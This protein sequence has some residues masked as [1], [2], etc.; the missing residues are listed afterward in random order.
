M[1]KTPLAFLLIAA[2]AAPALSQDPQ[3]PEK[4]AQRPARERQRQS[5]SD[6]AA[7]EAGKL[8]LPDGEAEV[9]YEQV[10]ARPDDIQ[11]NYRY[12]RAQVRRGEVK[13]AAA[14]LERILLVNPNLVRVRLFYALVLYRLDNLAE[15]KT[16]LELVLKSNPPDAL[17]AEAER[18]KKDVEKKSKKTQLSGRVSVGFQY[19]TNRNAAPEAGQ[20]LFLDNP[21]NLTGTGQ[22]RDDTSLLFMVNAEGRRDLG[23]QAGHDA[24]VTLSYYRA[25]QTL[26]K[27][28][29]LAAYSVQAGATY[30]RGKS[31]LVPSFL[32]DHVTLA[33]STY[34]RNRG[35]GLRAERKLDRATT[36]SL[37]LRAVYQ[38]YVRTL[39]VP[40]ADER[41]GSQWD[42]TL[43]V[44]RILAPKHRVTAGLGY[45]L[46][47]ASREYNAYQRT[48]ISGG[49]TWLLGK[50]AFLLTNASVNWDRYEQPDTAISRRFRRD[51]TFRVSGT[52]GAPL[53]L[54]HPK[55]KDFVGTLTYEHYHALSSL[56]NYEYM[57]NKISAL[58]TYKWELGL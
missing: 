48:T 33:Q 17:R 31:S 21:V 39:Q 2:L 5:E 24:F 49:H 29:N 41:D 15:A 19:D 22:R 57:N 28:L 47:N 45:S 16:Q 11:L 25:E 58:L 14:T 54:A 35:A 53:T 36:L 52:L 26:V 34:L 30:K 51:T 56:V 50:G 23:Y 37:D 9:T 3:D 4:E 13:G 38:D 55:L 27:T 20:R 44:G 18:Y 1:P 6:K 42:A 12:A 8:A 32:F 40:T 46:K 43:S 7:E 10:L